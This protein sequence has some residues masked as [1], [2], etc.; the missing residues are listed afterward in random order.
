MPN[1]FKT[2][3]SQFLSLIKRHKVLTS[4][5]ALLCLAFAGFGAYIGFVQIVV[6]LIPIALIAWIL[7]SRRLR[8]GKPH[9]R[10]ESIAIGSYI[11]LATVLT[12]ALIQAVPYGRAHSN[13]SIVGPTN[14]PAWKDAEGAAPGTT[15]D[16]MVRA[17]YGCHS[18]EVQYPS[19]ANVA[20]ISWMVQSHVDEG[21]DE[22]NYS[23]IKNYSR[24]EKIGRESIEVIQEGSMPPSYYTRFGLHPEAKLTDQEKQDLINGLAATFGVSA[25]S[26]EYDED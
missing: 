1:S 7:L 26:E 9:D 24:Q 21:R 18:N 11:A 13:G 23:E 2:F 4:V 17:C 14:E 5:L 16:L 10:S 22:V 19:Y 6:L 15:R 3:A 8:S 12:F 20:P 25:S